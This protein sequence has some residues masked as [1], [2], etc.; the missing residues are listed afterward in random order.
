MSRRASRRAEWWGFPRLAWLLL[1][2]GLSLMLISGTVLLRNNGSRA[3]LTPAPVGY[4]L[5][6]VTYCSYVVPPFAQKLGFSTRSVFDTR[7]DHV[8]GIAL[9]DVDQNLNPIRSYQDPTWSSA[10]YLG[11]P[12]LDGAGNIYVAPAPAISILDDPPAKSN[13]VYRIDAVTGKMAALIDLPAG[14]RP[15]PENSY[16]IMG[17]AYD[18]DT[19]SLYASSVFGST[20]SV[21]AGRLFRIDPGSGQVKSQID[22]LDAFGLAVFNSARGKRLY[23]GLARS[24]EVYSIGLD[25][26]GNFTSATRAEVSLQGLGFHGDE[27]ARLFFFGP[28]N[29][30]VQTMQF[31]FNLVAPTDA[32]QTRFEYRYDSGTDTW[33]LVS[34]TPI[35]S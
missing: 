11:F 12:I 3:A 16:G 25:A 19:N 21:Q 30:I 9:S 18:C 6:G 32:R 24:A 35:N 20:R 31:D 23:F 34:V 2:L 1:G 29:M 15:T 4:A 26:H 13:I 33:H 5:G 17:L 10:G 8:K 28:D 22:G 7:S 27:R 14:R